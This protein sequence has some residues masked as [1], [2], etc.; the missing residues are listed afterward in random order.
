MC[1]AS[2][3]GATVD[4]SDWIGLFAENP[5]RFIAA[6]PPEHA[7]ELQAIADHY[8]VPVTRKGVF[9]GDEIRFD[10]GGPE[11]AAVSVSDATASWEGA[12]P[13]RMG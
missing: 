13:R 6:V 2:G 7:H 12:I 5:H 11:S 4:F 1:I 10:N 3:V 9:G 8:D